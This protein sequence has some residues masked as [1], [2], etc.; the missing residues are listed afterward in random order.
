MRT[1][2][3]LISS[4]TQKD[5]LPQLVVRSPLRKL[6]LRDQD[7]FNPLAPLHY[8]R[9]DALMPAPWSFLRQV[10]KWARPPFDL[11]RPS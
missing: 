8:R 2:F 10:N 1:E 3:A 11:C 5:R 7:R 4:Q 6:D 9:S